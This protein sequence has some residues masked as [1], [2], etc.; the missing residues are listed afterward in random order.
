MASKFKQI[1]QIKKQ[2]SYGNRNGVMAS[3]D[4]YNII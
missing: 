3:L 4:L 1:M 2:N